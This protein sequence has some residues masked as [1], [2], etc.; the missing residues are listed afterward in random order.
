MIGELVEKEMHTLLNSQLVG[1]IGC[2]EF[3]IVY[4][5]PVSYAYD[6]ADVFVHTYAGMKIDI[7]RTNPDVCFQVDD[8]TDIGN[9]KSVIAWGRYEEITDPLKRSHAITL[10]MDRIL[11]LVSSATMHLGSTWPFRSDE[12]EKI[13]G[14]IFK[15]SL[16]KMTGKFERSSNSPAVTG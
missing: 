9:W 14:I 15:I 12:P 4:I 7:M 3:G 2:Q 8:L 13:D 6:G 10:L 5:V 16:Q 11:P 1:R